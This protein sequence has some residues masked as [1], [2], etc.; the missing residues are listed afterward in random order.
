MLSIRKRTRVAVAGLAALACA[1]VCAAPAGA[2]GLNAADLRVVLEQPASASTHHAP[3]LSVAGRAPALCVP[4]VA[5]LSVDDTD[6]NVILKPTSAA[7]CGSKSLMPFYSRLDPVTTASARI[8]PGQVYRTRIYATEH[9]TQSL[10]SFGLLDTS[11]ATSAP[12]PESGLWWSEASTETGA[13]AAGTGASIEMQGDRLAVGVF[14]FGETGAATWYFGTG[15]RAGHVARVPLVQLAN[16]DP[17]FAPVGNQPE[18]QPGPRIELEFLS[19]SRARAYLVRSDKG[20]DVEVRPLLLSRSRFATGPVGA[21]W[22]G[23]W[24]L[25]VDDGGSPRTFDFA[26]AGSQDAENFHLADSSGDARLDCR[27]V[28]GTEHP[29]LCSLSAASAPLA[30]FDQV[31]LDRLSGRANGGAHATLMRIPH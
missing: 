1:F 2:A 26:A 27:L 23:Q 25:V 19:P 9:G 15:Q 13:A 5:S 24:V 14:G 4:A 12:L 6:L 10:V 21:N 7:S 22:S 20:R 17:A 28:T 29:E 16:G 30:D 8:L 11:T 3:Q 18:A 31:G